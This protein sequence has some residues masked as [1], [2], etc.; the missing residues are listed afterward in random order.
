MPDH[1]RVGDIANNHVKF[2]GA[3]R[4]DELVRQ[5]RCAHL[6]LQVISGHVRRRYQDSFFER[7]GVFFAAVEKKCHV[8]IFF[9]FRDPQLA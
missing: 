4:S 8:G 7:E 3:N 2:P 9:R 6:G 1:V 5:F